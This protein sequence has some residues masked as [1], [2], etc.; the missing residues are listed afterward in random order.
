MQQD[1]KVEYDI[2]VFEEDEEEV[3]LERFGCPHCHKWIRGTD[4]YSS[5]CPYCGCPLDWK[6]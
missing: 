6:I 3:K 5:V 2:F 1:N 4:Y